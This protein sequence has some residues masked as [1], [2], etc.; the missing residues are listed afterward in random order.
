MNHSREIPTPVLS[1]DLPK[2]TV[3][4]PSYN[5]GAYLEETIRS[6]LNQQYPRLEYIIIDGGSTDGSVS[7]IQKYASRLAYWESASDRGQSHA[8]N[9]GFARATGEIFAWLNSDDVYEPGALFTV[10]RFFARHPGRG[11]LVGGC[12]LLS[13]NGEKNGFFP[14]RYSGRAALLQF[15]KHH[16]G[17]SRLPQQSSFWRT[18]LI[19]GPL[20]DESLHYAMDYHLW[21]RLVQLEAPVLIEDILAGYRLHES[22]KTLLDNDRFLPEELAVARPYWR[23]QGPRF[24][25]SCETGW[26]RWR[27]ERLVK[28]SFQKKLAGDLKG[29]GGDLKAAIAVFFP[30]LGGKAA[31]NLLLRL[32]LGDDVVD[33]LRFGNRS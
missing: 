1:A 3:V 31:F 4:T 5:Q 33:R 21:L 25:L 6:V 2:I 10:G 32:T 13:A 18:R 28:R 27:A 26:R 15:W 12:R 17:A 9:K 14:T 29:A 11:W 22:A 30:V 8:V 16:E 7:I 23:K 19:S 20:L 24:R